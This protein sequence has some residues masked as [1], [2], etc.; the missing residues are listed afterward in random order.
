MYDMICMMRH[1]NQPHVSVH[2]HNPQQAVLTSAQSMLSDIPNYVNT[3][4]P[5]L[6]LLVNTDTERCTHAE[7]SSSGQNIAS[8]D[9]IYHNFCTYLYRVHTLYKQVLLQ[10]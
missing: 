3:W 5:A 4:S 8:L 1:T 7:Y 2:K 6:P 10:S 9:F